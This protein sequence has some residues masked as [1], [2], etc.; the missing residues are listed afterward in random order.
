MER[1]KITADQ[2]F[3]LLVRASQHRNLKLRD[4]ADGLVRSGEL[5]ER[6]LPGLRRLERTPRQPA[7]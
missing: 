5:P 6:Q 3:G 1:H 2:A 4:V 7:R